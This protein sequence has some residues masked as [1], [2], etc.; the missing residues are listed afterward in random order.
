MSLNSRR[1]LNILLQKSITMQI[2]LLILSSISSNQNLFTS[3]VMIQL[4]HN[5]C[6]SISRGKIGGKEQKYVPVITVYYYLLFSLFEYLRVESILGPL[7]TAAMY[8]PIVPAPGD[9]EDGKFGGMNG[10]GRG[11]RS[12]RRKPDPT[13]LCPPQI[14]LARLGNEP[15]PPR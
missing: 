8:W 12:T 7:C 14:P 2:K 13:P 6:S 10:F 1:R 9:C 3:H 5:T 11:N 15:G 4:L